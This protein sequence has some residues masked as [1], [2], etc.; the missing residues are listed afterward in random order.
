MLVGVHVGVAP[1][2]ATEAEVVRVVAHVNDGV[3]ATAL[4]VVNQVLQQRRR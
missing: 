4:A 2:I 3:N 1:T